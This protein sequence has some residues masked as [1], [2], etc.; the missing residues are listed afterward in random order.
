MGIFLLLELDQSVDLGRN[1]CEKSSSLPLT[2]NG[3][4]FMFSSLFYE[5]YIIN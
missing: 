5:E 2:E 3:N 4:V 1:L